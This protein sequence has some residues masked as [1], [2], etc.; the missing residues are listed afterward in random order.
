MD[1]LNDVPPI[2]KGKVVRLARAFNGLKASPE[3]RYVIY[4]W[5][6]NSKPIQGHDLRLSNSEFE[7]FLKCVDSF[8]NYCRENN[9]LL[10]EFGKQY[11]YFCVWKETHE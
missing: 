9:I 5:L 7:S 8:C 11:F 2:E 4:G 10:N 1:T 3:T 6:Q